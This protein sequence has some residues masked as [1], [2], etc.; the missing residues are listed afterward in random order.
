MY[1]VYARATRGVP[2]PTNTMKSS[3][4][5]GKHGVDANQVD[6][7]LERAWTALRDG[8]N[9]VRRRSSSSS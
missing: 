8:T 1:Y 3:G 9:T 7:Q 5:V 2:G 4:S 6:L